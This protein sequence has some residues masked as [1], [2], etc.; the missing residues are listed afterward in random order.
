MKL[1]S[2]SSAV[3]AL[4][5]AAISA[6]V[7]SGCAAA[8]VETAE[9]TE[10]AAPTVDFLACAVSD[11]GSWNDKSFNEAVYDGLKR[12]ES[13]L[14]V[15]IK[16]AESNSPDDFEPNLQVMVDAA[17]D[18]TFGVGFN[19]VA[20]I[21]KVAAANP[22]VNFGAVDGWSEGNA[23]LKPIYYAMNQSSFLAGYLAAE[24]STTKVIGTYGGAQ[25][26]SVTDFMSGYY[27]GAQ[28]WAKDTGKS[29]KVL[30]WNPKTEKGDFTGNFAP[31]SPESKTISLA[32]LNAKADVIFPVGG[33]QFS[34][35][36]TAI[37]EVNPDAVMIGVD[38]DIALTNEAVAKYVLTS[39]EKRMA[40]AV[41]DII[42]ELVAGGAF[43]GGD[44][45]S[46]LGTLANGGTGLSPLYDFD[47]KI[48]QEVKDRL[49]ELEAGIIDG[50]INPLG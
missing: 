30:G 16:A 40:N 42:S 50:S 36:A 46:Y 5:L 35:V 29:I 20:P 25:I 44:E 31:N 33:D 38:K 28:Q 6:L 14:G 11:E 7:L 9:P 48:S 27:Y 43:V 41:F 12:A 39:A 1:F 34:A 4:S 21:N 22:T 2:R 49:A 18:I 24:Y 8:P 23:N 15:Q 3:S 32:Q 13:E 17:C 10:S 37:E 47:S 26:P 19:L 45:G